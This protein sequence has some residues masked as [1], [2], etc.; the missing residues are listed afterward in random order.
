MGQINDSSSR[1]INY[2]RVDE[3][4]WPILF[5]GFGEGIIYRMDFVHI[6]AISQ[7]MRQKAINRTQLN[8]R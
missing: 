1:K 8:L 7:L 4:N 5:F 3:L 2:F 6:V